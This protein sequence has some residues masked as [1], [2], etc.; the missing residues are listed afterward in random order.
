MGDTMTVSCS[1]SHI[2]LLEHPRGNAIVETRAHTYY[3]PPHTDRHRQRLQEERTRTQTQ[4]RTSLRKGGHVLLQSVTEVS[5]YAL[6]GRGTDT[7]SDTDKKLS[8]QRRTPHTDTHMSPL[9]EMLCGRGPHKQTRRRTWL[10]SGIIEDAFGVG[11]DGL[12]ALLEGFQCA[13]PS[14][15]SVCLVR[16][17]GGGWGLGVGG[18][19]LG[20]GG[21]GFMV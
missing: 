6:T 12:H 5:L 19:G 11:G 17:L 7:D 10:G 21:C 8:S 4:T 16:A 14:S 3:I 2:I 15:L 13:R 20:V 9:R 18:W 1:R